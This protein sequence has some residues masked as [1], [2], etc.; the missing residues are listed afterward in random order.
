[1]KQQAFHRLRDRALKLGH[2]PRMRYQFAI[3]IGWVRTVTVSAADETQ[4]RE[5]AHEEAEKRYMAAGREPPVAFDLF[6]I[7]MWPERRL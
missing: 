6:L 3:G 5:R 2:P 4:A 1:M 7:D